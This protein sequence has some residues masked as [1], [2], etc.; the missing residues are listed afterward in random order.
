MFMETQLAFDAE[1]IVA[2]SKSPRKRG[3][4]EAYGGQAAAA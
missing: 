3:P 2:T 1:P 4:S